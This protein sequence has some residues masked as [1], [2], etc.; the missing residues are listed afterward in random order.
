MCFNYDRLLERVFEVFQDKRV[1]A[2][3]MQMAES[4]L[5]SRIENKTQFRK[6]EIDRAVILLGIEHKNI[7]E[8]FFAIENDKKRSN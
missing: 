3:K 6:E 2:V 5:I 1:F 7:S 4:V 8:Y